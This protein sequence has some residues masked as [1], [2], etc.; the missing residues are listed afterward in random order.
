MNE[1]LIKLE[2]MTTNELTM[3]FEYLV[4]LIN[5]RKEQERLKKKQ[6]GS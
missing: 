1:I 4:E 2:E 5:Y 3:I 6:N